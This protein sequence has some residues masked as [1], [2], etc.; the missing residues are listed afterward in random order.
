MPRRSAKAV[1]PSGPLVFN[2]KPLRPNDHVFVSPPWQDRDGEPYLIARVLE[3]LQPTNPQ[4]LKPSASLTA[5][6]PPPPPPPP[7]L[8]KE[9]PDSLPA[10]LASL[11]LP[12][13]LSTEDDHS[14]ET[15]SIGRAP[16]PDPSTSSTQVS[17]STVT[18]TTTTSTPRTA[19]EQTDLRVRVAYYFRTRDITNRYVADHRLIVA[20]MHSD[21]VPASY[22]RGICRVM[23]KEHVEDLEAWKRQTDTFYWCQL[24]DRYL[25]RYFDALPTVRVKN[26]P[27]EVLDHLLSN[28]EF[29]LCE[30]NTGNQLC[31]AQRGCHAC[32]KWAA[33][34]ESVTCLRCQKVFHLTCLDPPLPAKPKAGYAWSCAP[35]TKA[36]EE[37]LEDSLNGKGKAAGKAGIAPPMRKAAE[38]AR[39]ITMAQYGS[40]KESSLVNIGENGSVSSASTPTT[41]GKG[42][43]KGK[44]ARLLGNPDPHD[45]KTT[46]GWPFR[47][48]GM[49]VNAYGVLDPHDS[50]YPR[51][52]TRLGNKFQCTVPE[53]DPTTNSEIAP[54]GPRNYY[55]PKKSRAST[56]SVAPNGSRDKDLETDW[57]EEKD[58][59]GA[60]GE[61]EKEKEKGKEKEKEP[62]PK[63]SDIVPRGE[64]EAL[65]II[66]RPEG[67]IDDEV[68][69]ILFND[70]KKL[71]SY[72]SA[73]VDV[74]NRAVK[75]LAE[76]NG[77]I[78]ATI[79]ALRKVPLA[80]LGHAIWNEA[81]RKQLSDGAAQYHNDI[82]EIAKHIKTKKMS[83]V[84]KK[85]YISIGHNLQEDELQQPEER[86][87]VASRARRPTHKKATRAKLKADEDDQEDDDHGS[88][89]GQPT[90]NTQRR[91][92]FCAICEETESDKWY[93][94][95]ENICELE[96]KPV[97]LVMCE[98]CGFRWRHYGAQYPPLAEELRPIVEKPEK[99]EKVEKAPKATKE[100]AEKV[101]KQQ[102]RPSVEPVVE[103]ERISERAERSQRQKKA[104]IMFG[105]EEDHSVAI[106]AGLKDPKEKE[107]TPAPKIIRPPI[108][109]KKPCV[110]CKRYEPK[111]ALY[112]CIKCTFSGH[113]SCYG[114]P[115]GTP[116]KKWF[117][118]LCEREK[119]HTRLQLHP[120]CVLCPP[121]PPDDETIYPLNAL[122][123]LKPTESN[124]FVH[125][126][127]SIWHP[128]LRF[129]EPSLFKTVEAFANLSMQRAREKCCICHQR[130]VG[131][132]IQCQEC[133]KKFHV[134]CAYAK[135][136][137]FA[138]EVQVPV[139]SNKK[140]LK[141]I[142]TVKFKDAEGVLT[143]GVWCNDHPWNIPERK[144]WD[145][146][147]RCQAGKITALQLYARD[148]KGPKPPDQPLRLRQAKRLD[149]VIEPVL[150]PRPPTPPPVVDRYR[151]SLLT[152]VLEDSIAQ[153][154][155]PMLEGADYSPSVAGSP[156]DPAFFPSRNSKRRS[157]SIYASPARWSPPPVGASSSGGGI[158][159]PLIGGQ[160]AIELPA[161]PGA[162]IE[163]M[164]LEEEGER[165]EQ[166]EGEQ[167]DDD[168]DY[169]PRHLINSDAD[170]IV[171]GKRV[172]RPKAPPTLIVNTPK[173]LKKRR[174]GSFVPSDNL[175]SDSP[176]IVATA[177]TQALPPLPGLPATSSSNTLPALPLLVP[178][179]L[180]VLPTP[181][182]LPTSTMPGPSHDETV[183]DPV[184]NNEVAVDANEPVVENGEPEPS[185]SGGAQG[186]QP[187]AQPDFSTVSATDEPMD[188]LSAVAAA[189]AAAD[190]SAK[191][192]NG[193]LPQDQDQDMAIDPAL[194]E[195]SHQAQEPEQVEE[196][197]DDS[198]HEVEA[199][200][201]LPPL[202]Q[203]NNSS[204][205]KAKSPV[206][207]TSQLPAAE[208]EQPEGE[209][210]QEETTDES[211]ASKRRSSRRSGPPKWYDAATGPPS[212]VPHGYHSAA[213]PNGVSSSTSPS[214]PVA[215]GSG[216]ASRPRAT[217]ASTS[218]NST[219]KANESNLLEPLPSTPTAPAPAPA[220]Y[221][222][223]PLLPSFARHLEAQR[224]GGGGGGASAYP[225]TPVSNGA[226]GGGAHGAGLFDYMQPHE[227]TTTPRSATTN[228][229]FLPA[230]TTHDSNSSFG[231]QDMSLDSPQQGDLSAGEPDFLQP[232]KRKRRRYPRGWQNPSDAMICANCQ[233][234]KSPLWRRNAQG[235]YECNACC[236]Y[237]KS[238]GHHRPP[239]VVDRGI[240]EARMTK[241]RIEANGGI[242]PQKSQKRSR[243]SGSSSNGSLPS[244][245]HGPHGGQHAFQQP[246][247]SYD[248]S[249]GGGIP[250][251]STS[252]PFPDLPALPLP[253]LPGAAAFN[254]TLSGGLAPSTYQSPYSY[255]SDSAYSNPHP[256]AY[257]HVPLAST[258]NSS[259]NPFNLPS[260][261]RLDQDDIQ[262]G[263]SSNGGQPQGSGGGATSG[264][265]SSENDDHRRM[266][267]LLAT[268]ALNFGPSTM[269]DD[270]SGGSNTSPS[271]HGGGGGGAN[272]QES[273]GTRDATT[274]SSAP[275]IETSLP[276]TTMAGTS[277][278]GGD[279]TQLY[280]PSPPPSAS[281]MPLHPLPFS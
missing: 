267:E 137:K 52:S 237:F 93:F 148:Y 249:Y 41:M 99:A 92:R 54:P 34:P 142:I 261:T 216:S 131:V 48:F 236:L 280:Q 275:D 158:V 50:L 71:R 77:D 176:L 78:P 32:S 242:A 45:W 2:G 58:K 247:F 169:A 153:A 79:A 75:L 13:T 182:P 69:E 185:T 269:D 219:S 85:Y 124:N 126:L 68:F 178:E 272:G 15:S 101:S 150:V 233:T 90:S 244:L 61:K 135:N 134:A 94:C 20:T 4:G 140:K 38:G 53:W 245:H 277:Q 51:A 121:P 198:D 188:A 183:Q 197:A 174:T 70:V 87:A 257:S 246:I 162:S 35:C 157:T 114:I 6:D 146:G 65:T 240:G 243:P 7:T 232:S 241:R 204:A 66:Y 138:F 111:T 44:Q 116:L 42:K 88:V 11:S 271:Q 210:T 125:L 63:K 105:D 166:G 165:G 33:S 119:T 173:Q 23:H 130:G 46:H 211:A 84:V 82:A 279:L 24:Y 251:I 270:L 256:L 118:E 266:L 139:V 214:Q 191:G 30:V 86:T 189:I 205:S 115:E 252:M 248:Q 129:S 179:A 224:T 83:D 47:Y 145:L 167:E 19:N 141:D 29:V 172:R 74:L 108:V 177:S 201:L 175:L 171:S 72:S 113:A 117:C 168:D 96:I 186:E 62:K 128:E 144:T 187:P 207:A 5:P 104:P 234:D 10:S 8:A 1:Q 159:L 97:P 76:N 27:Q 26:A 39:S 196:N 217:R 37:E 100:K 122:D 164:K 81:E 250:G 132:T 253:P 265:V 260:P 136:F 40:S 155:A 227:A 55:Q 259:Y 64:D 200:L 18:A 264:V 225:S 208:P 43:G 21:T 133:N 22:I 184:D 80:T 215:S 156:I 190:R 194:D 221:G 28:F 112:H 273:S 199:A 278:G 262:V 59:S 95:P 107:K 109:P 49:H 151:P 220:P 202:P 268:Q 193:S 181:P 25:H 14:S 147:S 239:R 263:G 98:P 73:G 170:L 238:H 17:K 149:A 229:S 254:S 209:E 226:I 180:P 127:C 276:M 195:S 218:S 154:Q 31:D 9:I 123:A 57:I 91:N 203:L 235:A 160:Q 161:L 192:A 106:K 60:G 152:A 274:S 222:G 228:Q 223:L 213:V 67:K 230:L 36:H 212:S 12:M 16:S 110:L 103:K 255:T 56:P 143:P 102:Q 258:S 163:E 231:Q 120:Q 3:V 206:R 281:V 89:C